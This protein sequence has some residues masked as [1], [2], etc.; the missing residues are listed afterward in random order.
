MKKP[1]V[2]G[3]TYKRAGHIEP[4]DTET[5]VNRRHRRQMKAMGIIPDI[6]PGLCVLIKNSR[7]HKMTPEDVFEQ[8]VSFVFGQQDFDNPSSRTKDEIRVMLKELGGV[9]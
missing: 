1:E 3:R 4:F 6:A 7:H 8:R 5:P 9:A 2:V